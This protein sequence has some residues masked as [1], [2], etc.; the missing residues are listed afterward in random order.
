MP[1]ERGGGVPG[2]PRDY[3]VVAAE[4]LQAGQVRRI[5]PDN[6]V[7]RDGTVSQAGPDC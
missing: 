1:G 6:S 7:S 3:D 5:I 2:A 4:L